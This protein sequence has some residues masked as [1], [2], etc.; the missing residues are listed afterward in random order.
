MYECELQFY[1]YGKTRRMVTKVSL[2]ESDEE[3]G[4]DESLKVNQE[5]ARR[6][7]VRRHRAA[8]LQSIRIPRKA[9]VGID[10]EDEPYE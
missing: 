6:L 8:K 2:F 1:L 4:E 7:E 3:D 5:F 10:M 9:S